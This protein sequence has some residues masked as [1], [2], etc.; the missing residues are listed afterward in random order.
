MTISRLI[1]L[2][3][4]A[5]LRILRL[6]RGAHL[7]SLITEREHG[8]QIVLG[9]AFLPVTIKIGE[10]AVLSVKGRLT[11]DSWLGNR[12]HVYIYLE[13][14]SRLEIDGDFNIGPGCRLVLTE[15]AQLR[16]GGCK[17]EG[18]SGMTERCRVMV[19][20]RVVIGSDMIC[21]WGVFIT[22]CDWHELI[23]SA[24]TEDTVIGNHVWITPNCSIL[25]GSVIGAGCIVGTGSVTHRAS[26]PE[27]SLIGGVPARVLASG[28][29]WSWGPKASK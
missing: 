25:K 13:R 2:P 17:R 7:S 8:A 24:N 14:G 12:E 23:G 1:R 28:R 6:M 10:G 29:E 11:L 4:S 18:V 20:R 19:R 15:G 21:A 3:W 27:R 9:D 5:G 16:I 22:D 26:Y